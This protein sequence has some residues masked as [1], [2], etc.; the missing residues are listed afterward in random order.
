[1]EV[2]GVVGEVGKE[3]VVLDLGLYDETDGLDVVQ[4]ITVPILEKVFHCKL[5]AA[6][7]FPTQFSDRW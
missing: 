4:S 1:M 3:S 7:A 6:T 5:T 2:L